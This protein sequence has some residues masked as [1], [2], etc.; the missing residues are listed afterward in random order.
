MRSGASPYSRSGG[1]TISSVHTRV[2]GIRGARAFAPSRRSLLAATVASAPGDAALGGGLLLTGVPAVSVL[3][4]SGSIRRGGNPPPGLSSSAL[5]RFRFIFRRS[6][7]GGPYALQEALPGARGGGAVMGATSGC[8][9]PASNRQ[10]TLAKERVEGREWL[11]TPDGKDRAGLG[12]RSGARC[13][14]GGG[15]VGC[16]GGAAPQGREAW[17]VRTRVERGGAQFRRLAG[18]IAASTPIAGSR[19]MRRQPIE[20][21]GTRPC[22]PSSPGVWPT[23]RRCRGDAAMRPKPRAKAQP[24]STKVVAS[25]CITETES[26]RPLTTLLAQPVSHGSTSPPGDRRDEVVH[27]RIGWA[28][29]SSMAS[30]SDVSFPFPLVPAMLAGTVDEG[31]SPGSADSGK[32]RAPA[33]RR[34]S[35]SLKSRSHRARSKESCSPGW[36]VRHLLAACRQ[37]VEARTQEPGARLG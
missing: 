32:P 2:W 26:G 37:W 17:A 35:H 6:R 21:T 22:A 8:S 31:C 28:Y 23:G 4:E 9:T 36:R 10:P 33:P 29:L 12:R 3:Q 25:C 20:S 14:G 7:P 1:A 16:E 5:P 24:S 19:V 30:I 11:P 15:V 18:G 13:S 34:A 27:G